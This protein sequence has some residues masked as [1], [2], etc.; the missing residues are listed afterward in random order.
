MFKTFLYSFCRYKQGSKTVLKVGKLQFIRVSIALVG[1]LR[2]YFY[3]RFFTDK[4]KLGFLCSKFKKPIKNDL[5]NSSHFYFIFNI[6]IKP[7]CLQ[8]D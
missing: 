6:F 2:T 7:I 4:R 8:L 1:N 5:K 3:V